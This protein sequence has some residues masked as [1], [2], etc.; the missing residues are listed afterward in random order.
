MSK[1]AVI[2]QPD[3]LPWT[4]FFHRLLRADLYIALDHAQFV[5][6]TSRSWTHRDQIKTPS[7]PRW[8]SLSVQKAPLGTPINEIRLS[9]DPAW[10]AA[11]LNLVREN[12][13]HTPHFA[14]IF[15]RLEALY[16]RSDERLVDMNLASIDLLQDLLGLQV[17]RILSSALSPAGSSNGMLAGLLR[18][19]GA[20]RYLSG[21]GARAYFDPAP[22][23]AAGIEVLWQ[24]FEHPEYPQPFGAFVPYLSAIDMLFNC[25]AAES[26]RLLRSL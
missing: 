11:N 25:G 6:G 9:P 23:A 8:L 2:H 20:V 16:A 12:Y 21:I 1:L 24:Q 10:R 5:T 19:A 17:P 22:F 7:G 13:R 14:E 4:G 26:A 18:Q 3:F 15:P